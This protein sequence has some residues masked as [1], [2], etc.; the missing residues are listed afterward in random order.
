MKESTA[1]SDCRR[2]GT[3]THMNLCRHLPLTNLKS[4][5]SY[6]VA[7]QTER[8]ITKSIKMKQLSFPIT[9][10]DIRHKVKE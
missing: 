6:C 10:T 3:K 1:N 4:S 9:A 5:E 7:R 8:K 2:D